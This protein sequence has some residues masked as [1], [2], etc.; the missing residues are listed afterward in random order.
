MYKVP[1]TLFM[2]YIL[3]LS[4]AACKTEHVDSEPKFDLTFKKNKKW[5]Q[6]SFCFDHIYNSS[7]KSIPQNCIDSINSTLS[8]ALDLNS[9]QCTYIF[10]SGGVS[11]TLTI[12]YSV[13]LSRTQEEFVANVSSFTV[14][15]TTFDS[16]K[17]KKE[18]VQKSGAK[19]E[20]NN[21]DIYL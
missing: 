7:Q 13:S 10:K 11:D 15:K 6:K 4:L 3:L 9:K 16:L 1:A 21:I 12:G 8:L 19:N 14:I 18:T 5:K 17:V 2:L 20:K